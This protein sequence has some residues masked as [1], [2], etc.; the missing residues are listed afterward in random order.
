MCVAETI[1]YWTKVARRSET[2]FSLALLGGANALHLCSIANIK[3]FLS[4][5]AWSDQKCPLG[6]WRAS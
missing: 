6:N 1:A 5:L 4:K 3:G 2:R